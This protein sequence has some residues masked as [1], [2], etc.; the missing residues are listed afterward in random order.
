MASEILK[1]LA[2][3]SQYTPHNTSKELKNIL[4]FQEVII[5][6]YKSFHILSIKYIV[7]ICHLVSFYPQMYSIDVKT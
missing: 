2:A 5:R 6:I 3:E 4:H 7:S 1:L